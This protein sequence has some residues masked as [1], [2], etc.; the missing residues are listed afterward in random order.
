MKRWLFSLSLAIALPILP[1]QSE[2]LVAVRFGD[3]STYTLAL[4][5][6]NG[7]CQSISERQG[8]LP[9][10]CQR[11]EK[12]NSADPLLTLHGLWPSLPASI[13]SRGVDNRRWMRFGCATRPVPD[14]PEAHGRKCEL[15]TPGLSADTSAQLALTMPGAGGLSCL[16]RY[17][18]TK[19]GACFGFNPNTYFLTMSRLSQEVN[20]SPLG[21]WLKLH[22]GKIISRRDFNNAVA[23]SFGKS[24][25]KAVKL[26]CHGN[27]AYLTG[28][29]LV[30]DA[31][32]INL[33]L[34]ATSFVSQPHPGN[35]PTQFRLNDRA[36]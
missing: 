34:S 21:M 35:C 27:P 12:K 14:Y 18:F 1:V 4:S 13:A 6:Q 5:W 2:P 33:P 32:R 20:Q 19:H 7:F 17:E 16:E 31:K 22:N 15:P 30:I 10:E 23:Q 26:T 36:L 29:Q 3:F 28:I 11:T 25:A 24:S 8:K 9:A